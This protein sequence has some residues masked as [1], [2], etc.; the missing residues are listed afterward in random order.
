MKFLKKGAIILLILLIP[1]MAFAAKDI[2]DINYMEDTPGSDFNLITFVK[3][4]IN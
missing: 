3:T 4:L 2:M 1:M